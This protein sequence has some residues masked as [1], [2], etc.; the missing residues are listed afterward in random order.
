M[1]TQTKFHQIRK[2]VDTRIFAE[3]LIAAFEGGSNYWYLLNT[4]EP[5]FDVVNRYDNLLAKQ[6]N[7]TTR[8]P[9]SVRITNAL[10]AID[11]LRIPIYDVEN[12]NEKHG[13]GEGVLC[14]QSFL[15]GLSLLSEKFPERFVS[16]ENGDYDAEDAD[17]F[18]QLCVFNDVIFG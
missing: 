15:T 4:D 2:T 13:Y 11:T 14:Q 6:E 8:N 16:I 1:D 10:L 18:F 5:W 9:L 7:R 17:V 12:P 3:S